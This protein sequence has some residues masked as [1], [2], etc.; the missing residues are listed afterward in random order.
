MSKLT[1]HRPRLATADTRRV[2]PAPHQA[3]AELLTSEHRAWRAL[4]LGRAGHRCEACGASGCRLFADHI[5]ERRDDGERLDPA[6]GQALCGACHTSK[7]VAE[8]AK[9]MRIT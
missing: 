8:R 5:V 4:V 7:T 6:N 2:R 3:D 9:R 1:L